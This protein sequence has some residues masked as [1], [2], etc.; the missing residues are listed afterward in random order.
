MNLIIDA[1]SGDF[2]PLEIVKGALRASRDLSGREDVMLT[3][4]GQED[5]IREVMRSEGVD[6]CPKN[7][8]VFH[9]EDVLTMEDDPMSIMK[10]KRNSSMGAA[11]NLVKGGA[12][13]M[14]SAGNTGALHAGSSLIVRKMKGVRRSAL[15]TILPLEKPLLLL[16]CGANPVVTADVLCQW[17]VLGS[18]YMESVMGVTNPRVGLLNNGAEEHKGTPVAVEAHHA[19]KNMPVNFIGNVE[20]KEVPCGVCDV[21]VTDGFTGNILLKYSEGFG[22]F[23]LKKLK[24]MFLKNVLSKISYLL[25]KKSLME[26]KDQFNASKYGG[27]LFLGLSRPVIKS[28]GSSDAEAI[29]A[30]VHQ[31][32]TFVE[33]G[34]IE[35]MREKIQMAVSAEEA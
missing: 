11:L 33:Q 25:T 30:S 6:E 10:E 1:M 28:H 27:A 20:G 21:L 4:V 22:K 16:D 34:T 15:A 12:D 31:A 18:I 32:V 7:I 3:L 24:T 13:A 8:S 14:I 26:I 35:K 29:R 19:L 5:K 17:A 2:A 9:A 23:F